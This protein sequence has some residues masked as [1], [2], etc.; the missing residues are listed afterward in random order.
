MKYPEA[1]HVGGRPGRRTWSARCRGTSLLD[2][3]FILSCF[4]SSKV[5]AR[6]IQTR[7][8]TLL[9]DGGSSSEV[10]RGTWSR[11]LLSTVLKR[12]RSSTVRKYFIPL[13][14][15]S[16]KGGRQGRSESRERGDSGLP[17]AACTAKLWN[18]GVFLSLPLLKCFMRLGG[19]CLRLFYDLEARFPVDAPIGGEMQHEVMNFSG[20]FQRRHLSVLSV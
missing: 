13:C 12:T 14:M 8:M 7:L 5:W 16:Q 1:R 10:Q 17:E 9:G 3:Y 11:S 4:R 19:N 15:T 2:G 6:S 20:W 18:F